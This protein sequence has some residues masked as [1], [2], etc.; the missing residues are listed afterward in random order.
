MDI[1][2]Y[3]FIH[4]VLIIIFIIIISVMIYKLFTYTQKKV[5]QSSD[6]ST[7]KV[8]VTT[9]SSGNSNRTFIGE[10]IIKKPPANVMSEINTA[11][12]MALPNDVPTIISTTKLFGTLST[13]TTTQAPT[14]TT[15]TTS[16]PAPSTTM[17]TTSIPAP[18]TTMSTTSTP[19]PIMTTSTTTTPKQTTTSTTTTPK[20]TTTST[21]TTPKL[22]LIDNPDWL[23][24]EDMKLAPW[25][26]GMTAAEAHT[27]GYYYK[28]ILI[29]GM[30]IASARNAASGSWWHVFNN[31]PSVWTLEKNDDTYIFTFKNNSGW[32]NE[33]AAEMDTQGNSIFFDNNNKFTMILTADGTDDA[34]TAQPARNTRQPGTNYTFN[35]I[36]TYAGEDLKTDSSSSKTYWGGGNIILTIPKQILGPIDR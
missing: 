23:V 31:T 20:Q 34:N 28:S 29:H 11:P 8:P 1:D 35:A 33:D 3:T 15:S 21:T 25:S 14:T 10:R 12:P 26:M 4:V 24:I 22:I 6:I 5:I 18:S 27:D 13:P 17:S 32:L 9:V 19:A 7:T 16:I 36:P 30:K 2:L